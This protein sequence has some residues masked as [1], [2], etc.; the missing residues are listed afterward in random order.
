MDRGE[1]T[2]VLWAGD[3]GGRTK[4]WRWTGHPGGRQRLGQWGEPGF[5][6]P[7]EGRGQELVAEA[8]ESEKVGLTPWLLDRMTTGRA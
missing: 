7:L 8:K 1:M 3:G 6:D 2:S 4:G 5:R